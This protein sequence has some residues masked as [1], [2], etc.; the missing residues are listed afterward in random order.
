MLKFPNKSEVL[1]I[2][3]PSNSWHSFCRWKKLFLFLVHALNVFLGSLEQT[4]KKV[5]NILPLQR[6]AQCL[7]L[8]LIRSCH[9]RL[10]QFLPLP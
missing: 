5:C 8:L 3:L 9:V 7:E 1:L 10:D 2:S 4:V 6:A